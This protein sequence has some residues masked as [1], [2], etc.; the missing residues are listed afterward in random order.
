MEKSVIMDS[1]K[2]HILTN[3]FIVLFAVALF[4]FG[5]YPVYILV[6]IAIFFFCAVRTFLT[7]G[8]KLFKL[9][10]ILSL[11]FCLTIQIV[12]CAFIV[13]G[14]ATIGFHDPA[15]KLLAIFVL[16]LPLAIT[17]YINV[18]RGSKLQLPSIKEVG[19]IGYAEL[20]ENKNRIVSAVRETR[21]I[22][23]NLS[24][25]N[26]K[27]IISMLPH[28]DVFNY[29]NNDSISPT[30]FEKAQASLDDPHVYIIISNTGTA[31]S[32]VIS[33][34]NK[35]PFNHASLSLDAELETTLSYNGG[36]RIY[37]PGLNPEII[38]QLIEAKDSSVLIYRLP[39]TREQK[40]RIINK[41]EQI[42]RDGSAYNLLGLLINHSFKP[43]ILYCS[44]FVYK[45][46]EY[47]GLS[48]FK[49]D[50]GLIKPTDLIEKD[51]MRKLE[52]VDELRFND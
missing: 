29:V 18:G 50:S 28:H 52:F 25:D 32:D 21:R 31:A 46:L 38:D 4:Y 11:G 35:K 45:I 44:Q 42:N 34:F 6:Y 30:F 43:N 40:L 2:A 20:Y 13:G 49:A 39:C 1:R 36:N 8:S 41:I 19:T 37:P 17:R 9:L 47:G 3:I 23:G 5:N 26:L 48:Y 14:K 15:Y 24:L 22:R 10:L 51:Y 7:T 27:D 12:I 33:I 16:F